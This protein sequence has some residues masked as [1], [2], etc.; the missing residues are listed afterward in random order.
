MNDLNQRTSG[1]EPWPDSVVC[2]LSHKLSCKLQRTIETELSN[3]CL[4]LHATA[5]N[6]NAA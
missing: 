2:S 5:V 4:N 3:Q 1:T 6:Q